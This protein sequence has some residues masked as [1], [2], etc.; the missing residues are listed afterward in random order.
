MRLAAD[1]QP[2][3]LDCTETGLPANVPVKPSIP[4]SEFRWTISS[5]KVS[6]MYFARR[7]SPGRRQASA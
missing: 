2:I 3:P 4:R 5:M 6:A 7:G 1:G